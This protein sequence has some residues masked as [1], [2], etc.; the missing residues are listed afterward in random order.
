MAN[1]LEPI[2]QQGQHPIVEICYVD[3]LQW[4]LFVMDTLGPVISGSFLLYIEVFLFQR[5][6]MY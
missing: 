2:W 1:K 4:N 5:K 6:K 3:I